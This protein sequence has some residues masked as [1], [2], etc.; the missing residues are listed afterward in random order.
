MLFD[1]FYL[2]PGGG[3]SPHDL[4]F[5]IPEGVTGGAE[6]SWLDSG[7]MEGLRPGLPEMSHLCRLYC[8]H[9][10]LPVV[11]NAP[12]PSLA[13]RPCILQLSTPVSFHRLPSPHCVPSEGPKVGPVSL[14]RV[15]SCRPPWASAAP[16]LPTFPRD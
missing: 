12:A 6:E 5:G 11:L 3:Q 7:P 15:T 14:G 2:A 16:E 9:P 1:C 8:R 13:P 10:G 4:L